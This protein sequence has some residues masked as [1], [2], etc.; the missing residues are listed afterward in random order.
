MSIKLSI[1]DFMTTDI[2]SVNEDVQTCDAIKKMVEHNIGSIVVKKNN[3]F[4]GIITER[5]V[6]NKICSEIRNDFWPLKTRGFQHADK[7]L[8]YIDKKERSVQKY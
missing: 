7:I 4:V 8:Q 6:L 5:D 3:E 2:I 1:K